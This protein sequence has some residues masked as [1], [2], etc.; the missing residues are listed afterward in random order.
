MRNEG[1]CLHC[2]DWCWLASYASTCQFRPQDKHNPCHRLQTDRSSAARFTRIRLWKQARHVAKIPSCSVGLSQSRG[3]AGWD[4]CCI[5][6][7]VCVGIIF[8][9]LRDDLVFP[10]DRVSGGEIDTAA[11]D[12]M[13]S[14]CKLR[15]DLLLLSLRVNRTQVPASFWGD[16][17]MRGRKRQGGA[18]EKN[19][20]NEISIG[21]YTERGKTSRSL[22][23]PRVCRA[24]FAREG[25]ESASIRFAPKFRLFGR[26]V[27]GIARTTL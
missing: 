3:S 13:P 4:C 27:L 10:A 1:A 24:C 19:L 9:L 18:G 12:E 25:V 23:S 21:T 15:S 11:C 14:V 20:K 22:Y 5:S 16:M 17:M 8:P 7:P 2:R 6:H 26:E